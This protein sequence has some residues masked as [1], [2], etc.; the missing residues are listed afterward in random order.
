MYNRYIPAAEEYA[1]VGIKK[2]TETQQ[3]TRFSE[4]NVPLRSRLSGADWLIRLAGGKENGAL[5]RLLKTWNLEN[6]D[7]GDLLVLLILLLLLAEG[8]DLEPVVALGIF[9]FLELTDKKEEQT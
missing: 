1:P 3:R 6:L 2:E 9:L 5:G 7:N 4:K 8:E